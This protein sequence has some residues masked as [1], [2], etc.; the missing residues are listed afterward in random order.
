MSWID[1]LAEA[2]KF[3]EELGK[4]A[5]Q[6]IIADIEAGLD[7]KDPGP[8]EY[9]TKRENAKRELMQQMA[10]YAED[11]PTWDP[12]GKYLCGTCYYRELMDW[13]NTPACY[14]VEGKISMETGSCM[15]YRHGNP[16]SEW[17][18]LPVLHRYTPSEAL[19]AE[20]PKVKGFGCYPRCEYGSVAEGQD[21]D[22]REIWCGQFGV[23]VR[24]KACC[25]FEDGKDLVQI[26]AGGPGSGC[27]P[28]TAE[29]HGT[30]CGPLPTRHDASF[31]M[32][33]KIGGPQGS[34]PGGMYRNKGGDYNYVKLY[35]DS[36]QAR[37]ELL[38]NKIYGE[39]S[40]P[41]PH[42][43]TFDNNGTTAIANDSLEGKTVQQMGAISPGQAR[44]FMNGFAAD[45][46][47]AN[48]D[49][50]G[51]G[52]DNIFVDKGGKVVRLDQGGT[53]LKRAKGGDKPEA[54]L[55]Q[56][57][58][59]QNFF[60]KNPDYAQVAKIAG[61]KSADDLGEQTGT[62]SLAQQVQAIVSLRDDYKGWGAFVD[63]HVSD[64]PLDER[65]K[66][67]GMLNQRTNLLKAAVAAE[68]GGP[69]QPTQPTSPSPAPAATPVK[70]ADADETPG[71]KQLKYTPRTWGEPNPK[72][73]A[74]YFRP[75][76]KIATV[77][78]KLADAQ[79]QW[80][81]YSKL[82][83]D[84]EQQMGKTF[85]SIGE[86]TL[87]K[88]GKES[89]M[90]S[91][92]ISGDNIRMFINKA[93]SKPQTSTDV[94][95]SN[96]K[97]AAKYAQQAV[98]KK[99]D[100][101]TSE[102]RHYDM[103]TEMG[104]PSGSQMA[105]NA[106]VKSWTGDNNSPTAQNWRQVAMSYYGRSPEGDYTGSYSK[107]MGTPE[108]NQRAEK[109]APAAMALKAY[110]SEYARL[111]NVTV[112]YR[113]IGGKQANEIIQA[114]KDAEAKGQTQVK[115]ANNSL[116]CWSDRVNL[117]IGAGAVKLRMKIDPDN[118]W[119][120]HSASPHLFSSHPNER[121][122]MIGTH[123][124]LETFDFKDI[125]VET[126]G[127]SKW[128][129]NWDKSMAAASDKKQPELDIKADPTFYAWLKKQAKE[130]D[131]PVAMC[132]LDDHWMYKKEEK[133]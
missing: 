77:Y 42:S 25:A 102:K 83:S 14:I 48:W 53:F 15:F 50:V 58:E 103:F 33:E 116:S 32:H 27:N 63:A 74:G 46:L 79:G 71:G 129:Q 60:Q 65:N 122:Y 114:M 52:K 110:S 87:K 40:V 104:V 128:K 57:T 23:H 105:L 35:G 109:M 51:L 123:Q 89:G 43:Q 108:G 44:A 19:Y 99:M 41:V 131:I 17:N 97:I 69:T 86:K 121:E 61:V 126:Y 125:S 55:N 111:N 127:N 59:M 37:G 73:V 7:K 45:V 100:T 119:A 36:K 9:D 12:E 29:E 92:E 112:V 8:D 81:S 28:E 70:T 16:D 113:N 106:A 47:T 34:N 30:K 3:L 117:G 93:G 31:F 90:W 82:K 10:F 62:K 101:M 95:D 24:A 1:E 72:L 5:Q 21:K 2:N 115:I 49:A 98:G 20:R 22:G 124:P 18:P 13:G 67:V 64:M 120:V 85:Y 4:A 66:I 84:V 94:T 91:V 130:S 133:K 78:Q 118:V 107:V 26:E 132:T 56:I 54:V 88:G 80:Q 68:S 75:G 39:L 11:G 96:D 6:G 76:T 38:A